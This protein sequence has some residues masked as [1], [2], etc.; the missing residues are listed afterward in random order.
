MTLPPPVFVLDIRPE[1]VPLI[2]SA[3]L[4]AVGY[5]FGSLPGSMLVGRLVG[6]DPAAQGERNPGSANIWKLA[7]PGPGIAA[8][9]LDLGRAVLPALIGLAVAGWWGA[10]TA[11]IGAVVGSMRP[12]WPA[13]RG[14]RGVAAGIG[15]ALVLNPPAF[16]VAFGTGVLVY[17]V[18]R[19]RAPAITAGIAV[20]PFA[21]ALLSV[22]T[23]AEL[24][25]LAG[26]GGLY[27]VLVGGFW[28][29]RRR[30]PNG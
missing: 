21:F 2:M 5:V 19:Q 15:V 23:A 18:G 17:L 6:I 3:G 20:Y 27:L 8:L 28:L 7:G 29:T 30:S 1:D 16:T 25:A 9:L 11:G 10:W 14:G 4:L 26:V 22:R 12:V 24:L 13:L